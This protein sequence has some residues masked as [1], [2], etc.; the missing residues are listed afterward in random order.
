MATVG[1]GLDDSSS[2]LR[3]RGDGPRPR[4]D[5][6][7]RE[8]PATAIKVLGRNLPELHA[9]IGALAHRA[10]RLGTSPLALRDTGQGD[11]QHAFVVLE[12]EP[13]PLADWTAA[14][15]VDRR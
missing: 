5:S 3:S 12:G 14:A 8:A 1:A 15:V 13:P 11:D 10:E 4:A 7:K 6:R 2:H 9:R